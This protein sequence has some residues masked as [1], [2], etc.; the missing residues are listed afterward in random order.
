MFQFG[1]SACPLSLDD[2]VQ[3]VAAPAAYSVPDDPVRAV[4]PRLRLSTASLRCALCGAA[5]VPLGGRLSPA[6]VSLG[7]TSRG[8][9]VSL[10]CA[11]SGFAAPGGRC[12]CWRG[13][14]CAS[15]SCLLAPRWCVAPRPVWSLWVLRSAFPSLWCVPQRQ[16]LSRP[17]LLGGC[18]GHPEAKIPAHGACHW[19]LAKAEA[20]GS[21]RVVPVQGPAIGSWAACAAVVWSVW[22]LSLTRLVSRTF[23]LAT[24]AAAAAPGLFCV[25]TDISPFGSEDATPGYR[26]CVCVLFLVE[27]GRSA[28]KAPFVAPHPFF[29]G[30][31]RCSLCL[32][33]PLRARVALVLVV[34]VCSCFGLFFRPLCLRCSVFCCPGC[35]GPWRVVFPHPSLFLFLPPPGF[36][37]CLLFL[38]FSFLRP[39]CPRRSVFSGLGGL[40]PCALVSCL[41]PGPTCLVFFLASP[42]SPPWGFFL[43]ALPVFCFFCFVFFQPALS[44]AFCVFRSGVPWALV[45]SPPPPLLFFL[46][47]WHPP[48]AFCCM[49]FLCFVF[50]VFFFLNPRSLRRSVFS[51]PGCLG[52]WC[53]LLPLPF[54]SFSWPPPRVF[55]AWFFFCGS[56]FFSVLRSA[57]LCWLCGTRVV[58][59]S[60]AVGGVGA[61]CAPAGAG[62]RLRCAVSCALVVPVLCGALL[63]VVWRPSGGA[64]LAASLFPSL[65]PCGCC[66]WCPAYVRCS[67][68]H[69]PW[70]LCWNC[71]VAPGLVMLSRLALVS[72]V[73]VSLL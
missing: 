37:F 63:P 30:R 5:G 56:F 66:L 24:G 31:S 70:V 69:C 52:P 9:V 43:H 11:L 7:T 22:T 2:P 55:F 68:C 15:L 45:S 23:R 14:R 35:L 8:L 34:A 40:G 16:G 1:A 49:L 48:R 42:P 27:S 59:V 46:F 32:L 21:L 71:R 61:C 65:P 51:V 4:G 25:D 62:L 13:R 53:L 19:Q 33:R 6:C 20:L 72:V 28:S 26:G 18:A 60:W 36:F 29:C 50:F 47:F 58:G 10:C 3:G 73:L 41:S 38:C 67:G 12:C 64:L 57:M 54:F 39:S 17:D 44:P